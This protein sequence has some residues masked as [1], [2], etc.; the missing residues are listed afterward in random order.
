VVRRGE[1]G[2]R[3]QWAGACEPESPAARR[4]LRSC[5]RL[6]LPWSQLL[7]A[8]A[9]GILQ[10]G[11]AP[12]PP[13]VPCHAAH[14]RPPSTPP[15]PTPEHGPAGIIHTT[16]IGGK[17]GRTKETNFG[18]YMAGL[19]VRSAQAL[20]NFQKKYGPVDVGL[21]NAGAIRAD[22]EV[23]C[24]QGGGARAGGRRTLQPSP[25]DAC[26]QP[27]CTQM[28]SFRSTA[29]SLPLMCRDPL[30]T[31]LA[32]PLA[33]APPSPPPAPQCVVRRASDGA[34]LPQHARHQGGRASLQAWLRRC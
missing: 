16:L 3:G 14:S 27:R 33:A 20:P 22:V 30:S 10:G 18:S 34:A 15:H 21:V 8:G 5:R 26:L 11:R 4:P 24:T 29:C 12:P 13:R 23:R 6:P 32:H 17:A 31:P 9:C 19:L 25:A 1:C 2:R 28:P 7:P